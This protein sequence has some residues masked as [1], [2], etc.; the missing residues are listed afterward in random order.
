MSTI[1]NRGAM[2]E[3]KAAD[4]QQELGGDDALA[5][6][7][8]NSIRVAHPRHLDSSARRISTRPPHLE[9]AATSHG[10]VRLVGVGARLPRYG[11]EE[12]RYRR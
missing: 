4:S 9:E 5:A 12:R 7:P 11:G 6:G 2:G 1:S 3:E 10:F 8:V